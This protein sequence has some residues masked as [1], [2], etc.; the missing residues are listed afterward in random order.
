MSKRVIPKGL[1][2]NQGQSRKGSP[3]IGGVGART[4]SNRRA[5]LINAVHPVPEIPYIPMIKNVTTI[6]QGII[7]YLVKIQRGMTYEYQIEGTSTIIKTEA[8]PIHKYIVVTGLTNSTNQTIKL[9]AVNFDNVKSD[10]ANIINVVPSS[11]T[12]RIDNVGLTTLNIPIGAPVSYLIVGGGGG[13][14][15]SHDTGTGGGGG[16]GTVLTGTFTADNLVYSI[17][18]GGGGNGGIGENNGSVGFSSSI[19]GVAVAL[20]GGGGLRSR[21]GNPVGQGGTKAT[22]TQRSTGGSGGGNFNNN[23]G[24]GGGGGSNGDGGSGVTGTGGAG[25]AGTNYTISNITGTYGVGGSGRD[26]ISNGNGLDGASNTGNGGQGA[27]STSSDTDNGG[28]GGSGLVIV[29][30]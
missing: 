26:N 18:V 25:G 23:T 12:N 29:F 16:G 30:Y 7:L 24:S 3:T 4:I 15:G 13:G 8:H 6:N 1:I 21:D 27:G 22:S 10:W 28:Q 11:T 17:N 2:M 14:G 9:R 19:S 5:I 20:G